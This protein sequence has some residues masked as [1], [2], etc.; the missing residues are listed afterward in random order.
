M[1]ENKL[2]I[3]VNYRSDGNKS[4][5]DIQVPKEQ[6]GLG[7]KDSAKILSGGIALLIKAGHSRGD[8]KDYEVLSEII[9]YLQNEFISNESFKDVKITDDI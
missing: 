7:V 8:F 5:F 9:N 3:T 4:Y 1:K 6:R 2:S